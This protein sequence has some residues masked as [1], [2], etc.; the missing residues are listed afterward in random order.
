[1]GPIVGHGAERIATRI[2]SQWDHDKR[3][4][5]EEAEKE[6]VAGVLMLTGGLKDAD[7]PWTAARLGIERVP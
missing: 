4:Y 6:R 7:S 2:N 3:K 5:A 1:V